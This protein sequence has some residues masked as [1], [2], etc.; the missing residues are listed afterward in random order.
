MSSTRRSA[1]EDMR[2]DSEKSFNCLELILNLISFPKELC[3]GP[4]LTERGRVRNL[5]IA[6]TSDLLSIMFVWICE[7]AFGI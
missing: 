7:R 3:L 4:H 1:I 6:H 5:L 2:G